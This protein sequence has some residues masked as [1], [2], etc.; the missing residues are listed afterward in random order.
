M[1]FPEGEIAQQNETHMQTHCDSST[2][3]VKERCKC[4]GWGA[5]GGVVESGG[6]RSIQD[7]LE[8]L[9]GGGWGGRGGQTERLV[10]HKWF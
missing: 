3:I 2:Q 10:V 8:S 6:A 7:G 1:L 9:G 4:G 5:E